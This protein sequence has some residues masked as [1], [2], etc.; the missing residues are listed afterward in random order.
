MPGVAMACVVGWR[1]EVGFRPRMLEWERERP[2]AI[3]RLGCRRR[4]RLEIATFQGNLGVTSIRRRM[5]AGPPPKPTGPRVN[6]RIT[7]SQV[8]LVD[9]DGTNHGIV[10]IEDA[11]SMADRAGMDLVEVSPNAEPP[12]CKIADYGQLKYQAQKQAAAAR[13]KQKGQELKEIKM[14][15]GID[16]HDYDV[17]LKNATKFLGA[18]HKVKVTLRFRGREMRHQDLGLDVLKRVED[19]LAEC[20]RIE[21]RPKME[22]RQAV[23]VMA[24]TA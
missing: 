11:R 5:M 12:V 15:P 10:P 16:T 22:G 3:R 2:A 9:A 18:G 24:P 20:A 17:K 14:R 13:K 6:E 7:E 21:S 19:D 8:R 23:M 1:M 4:P